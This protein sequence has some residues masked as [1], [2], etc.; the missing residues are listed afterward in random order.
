MSAVCALFSCFGASAFVWSVLCVRVRLLRAVLAAVMVPVYTH[1]KRLKSDA[2]LAGQ[3]VAKNVTTLVAERAVAL[4]QFSINGSRDTHTI[5]L[6][7]P[8]R[9]CTASVDG[10][11]WL[12]QHH[13]LVMTV[14]SLLAN[15]AIGWLRRNQNIVGKVQVLVV[16]LVAE[17]S[18]EQKAL[19]LLKL[20]LLFCLVAH[21][22]DLAAY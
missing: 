5:R 9:C 8:V 13:G 3:V 19:F 14:Y 7:G 18:P 1:E 16:V 4:A 22:H 6:L 21:G 17:E 2:H 12:I 10:G 11:K 20:M 15:T